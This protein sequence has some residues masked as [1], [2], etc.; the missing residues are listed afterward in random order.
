MAAKGQRLRQY[1][2]DIV[3]TKETKSVFFGLERVLVWVYRH[4]ICGWEIDKDLTDKRNGET[5]DQARER[6]W[7]GLQF[8]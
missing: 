5:F 3:K 4:D 8:K 7:Q 6:C 1:S 2:D